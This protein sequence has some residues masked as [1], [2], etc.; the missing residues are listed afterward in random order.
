V[1]RMASSR[2]SP[3]GRTERRPLEERLELTAVTGAT[4]HGVE[5]FDRVLTHS[6]PC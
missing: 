5:Y 1:V 6:T 4:L 2:S 3:D